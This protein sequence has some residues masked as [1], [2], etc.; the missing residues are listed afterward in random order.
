MVG[1]ETAVFIPDPLSAEEMSWIAV[2]IPEKLASSVVSSVAWPCTVVC[3][4]VS[5]LMGKLAMDTARL[6]TFCRSCEYALEPVNVDEPDEAVPEELVP[7]ELP[8]ADCALVRLLRLDST[9]LTVPINDLWPSRTLA[10]PGLFLHVDAPYCRARPL[11]NLL[12][13]PSGAKEPPEARSW[14][15]P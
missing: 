5:K 11:V 12:I 14:P 13:S 9:L 4:A 2:C 10:R 8:E 3:C 15:A 7:E 1:S 6:I